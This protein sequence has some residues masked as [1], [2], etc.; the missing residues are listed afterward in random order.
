MEQ[1]QQGQQQQPQPLQQETR[2]PQGLNAESHNTK[3]ARM[4]ADPSQGFGGGI[5]PKIEE[6]IE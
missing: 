3:I 2:S 5:P 1:Q 4:E 6:G